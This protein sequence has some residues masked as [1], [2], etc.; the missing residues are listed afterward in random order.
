MKKKSAQLVHTEVN[1]W[2]FTATENAELVIPD[3]FEGKKVLIE[4]GAF[5]VRVVVP[6]KLRGVVVLEAQGGGAG[7]F[8]RCSEKAAK[9]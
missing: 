5:D 3:S 6:E 9:K 1:T 4:H 2:V 7:C 8:I